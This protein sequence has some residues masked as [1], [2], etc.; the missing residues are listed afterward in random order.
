[1]RLS[2]RHPPVR[3]H[4]PSSRELE[5]LHAATHS[6][7]SREK[8]RGTWA[9]E[10]PHMQP[11][12]SSWENS[13]NCW[14]RCAWTRRPRSSAS[15]R[16]SSSSTR[17]ARTSVGDG[18]GAHSSSPCAPLRHPCRRHEPAAPVRLREQSDDPDEAPAAR[19]RRH[20]V[21]EEPPRARE[22]PAA[23]PADELEHSSSCDH[24]VHLLCLLIGTKR[25][26]KGC[27][28]MQ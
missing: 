17:T 24:S 10:R 18:G 12:P 26:E 5:T 21:H 7:A 22:G 16:A 23:H 3:I 8:R 1:M 25:M 28:K 4:H 9:T 27:Y 20:G 2:L 15:L 13:T 11:S 14:R 6:G 19:R